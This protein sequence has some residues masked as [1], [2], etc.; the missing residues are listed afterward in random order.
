MENSIKWAIL[1]IP[2]GRNSILFRNN[3]DFVQQ[4]MFYLN[5]K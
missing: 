4:K 1:G 5:S 3:H 2:D